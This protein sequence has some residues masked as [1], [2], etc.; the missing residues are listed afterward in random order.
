MPELNKSFHDRTSLI[1]ALAFI[2]LFILQYDMLEWNDF[3]CSIQ[4]DIYLNI[5]RAFLT[6][7]ML[8][9]LFR[10]SVA[11]PV[12]FTYF[13]YLAF[14]PYQAGALRSTPSVLRLLFWNL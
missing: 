13:T 10:I 9:C 2:K 1:V 3:H 7:T 5:H 12:I 6:H 11:D 4:C 14:N 8:L